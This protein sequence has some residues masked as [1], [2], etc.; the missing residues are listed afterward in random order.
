MK[1]ESYIMN[2]LKWLSSLHAVCHFQTREGR[3]VGRASTSELK[4]W[5]LNK[6]VLVNGEPLSWDEE[7]DFPI[8][9]VI[10]FPKN[11]ITLL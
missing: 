11:K 5:C 6:A 2:G 8:F 7:I 9:S 4:R 10:F 1:G 3:R